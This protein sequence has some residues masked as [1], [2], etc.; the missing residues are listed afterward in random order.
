[1]LSFTPQ[2]SAGGSAA[3]KTSTRTEHTGKSPSD[4]L[5][6]GAVTC[7]PLQFLATKKPH[8]I[9]KKEPGAVSTKGQH[10]SCWLPLNNKT[11]QSKCLWFMQHPAN[12]ANYPRFSHA[13]SELSKSFM[14]PRYAG[15]EPSRGV[16]AVCAF[17]WVLCDLRETENTGTVPVTSPLEH[18]HS[19]SCSSVTITFIIIYPH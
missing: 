5:S 6:S 17:C 15:L 11:R 3:K 1:M 2:S 4:T 12:L 18:N 9:I 7:K 8:I 19:K 13:R 10:L 16:P 14:C